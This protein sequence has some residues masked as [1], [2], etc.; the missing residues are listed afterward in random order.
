MSKSASL[1]GEAEAKR[2]ERLLR[3]LGFKDEEI[4]SILLELDR[5][6]QEELGEEIL[7]RLSESDREK[8]EQM[9]KENKS[10]VEIGAWLRSSGSISPEETRKIYVDKL[11]KIVVELES[12]AKELGGLKAEARKKIRQKLSPPTPSDTGY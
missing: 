12:W 2:I 5:A 4:A 7:A 6:A 3:D 11:R 8:V 1:P 10:L 9:V